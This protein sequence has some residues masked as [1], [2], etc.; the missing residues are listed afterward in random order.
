MGCPIGPRCAPATQLKRSRST[1]PEFRPVIAA[2]AHLPDLLRIAQ[3]PV[4][5]PGCTGPLDACEEG[6][7]CLARIRPEPVPGQEV[8]RGRASPSGVEALLREVYLF[9]SVSTHA[10][11]EGDAA[12]LEGLLRSRTVRHSSQGA[13]SN[14]YQR[15]VAVCVGLRARFG[16][17]RDRVEGGCGPYPHD[18]LEKERVDRE[19][20]TWR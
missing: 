19:C 20:R 18:E 4:T 11:G 16:R 13:D 8:Q 14:S 5:S 15:P 3:K 6:S 10:R 9:A 2:G 12:A 1:W 7:R 17:R